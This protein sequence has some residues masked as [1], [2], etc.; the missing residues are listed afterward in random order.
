MSSKLITARKGYKKPIRDRST[1]INK[2]IL[3]GISTTNGNLF[4]YGGP[5]DDVYYNSAKTTGQDKNNNGT[6]TGTSTGYNLGDLFSSIGSIFNGSSGGS[7]EGTGT[8][9]VK[10]GMSKGTKQAIAGGITTA[11]SL[12]GNAFKSGNNHDNT[13]KTLGMAGT[14]LQTAGTLSGNVWLTAAGTA[15]KLADDL[16]FTYG[17][18][19]EGAMRDNTARLRNTN[20]TGRNNS[21]LINQYK[22]A[23]LYT[24]GPGKISNG[25]GTDEGDE[26]ARSLS[27]EQDQAYSQAF[28]NFRNAVNNA[29]KNQYANQ[30]YYYSNDYP[31]FTAFGGQLDIKD[32]DTNIH[33]NMINNKFPF[34]GYYET[35]DPSTAIGYSLYTDK[36]INNNNK[37]QSSM[38]NLFAG[39]PGSMFSLGGTTNT[40]GASFGTGLTH[41][42]TGGSHE[43]NPNDGVQ[44]GVDS[45]NVPNL[46]EEGEVIYDDYVFSNRLTIPNYKKEYDKKK[47]APYEA[48]VLWNYSD[49]SFAD[50]AKKIEKNTG[51]S[52]RPED[53]VSQR[54]ME[55]DLQVLAQVQEKER[56]KE[57]LKEIQEAIDNMTP[58]EFAA[59]QQQMQ[60]M[61]QQSQQEEIAQQEQL[62]Q[63]EAMQQQQPSEEELAAMQQQQMAAQEMQ[64][65][66]APQQMMAAN[67]GPINQN[68][69]SEGGILNTP[70]NMYP[71]GGDFAKFTQEL[72]DRG[73]TVDDYLRYLLSQGKIDQD[74]MDFY[75]VSDNNRDLL[76]DSFD[77]DLAEQY[78]KNLK[79]REKQVARLYRK[80]NKDPKKLTGA[81]LQKYKEDVLKAS[82]NPSLLENDADKELFVNQVGKGDT[83]SFNIAATDAITKETRQAYFGNPM[84]AQENGKFAI[85]Y[86]RPE[87]AADDWQPRSADLIKNPITI[88]EGRFVDS[89]GNEIANPF[90][91]DYGFTSPS[92][93]WKKYGYVNP[94]DS[95]WTNVEYNPPTDASGNTDYKYTP[96]NDWFKQSGMEADKYEAQDAYLNNYLDFLDDI[97]NDESPNHQAALRRLY[98]MGEAT[99][100]NAPGELK[101]KNRYFDTDKEGFDANNLSLDNLR[102]VDGNNTIGGRYVSG[103]SPIQGVSDPQYA[104]RQYYADKDGRLAGPKYY[105]DLDEE[106]KKNYTPL[107]HK[108]L[109]RQ[110]LLNNLKARR[111]DNYDTDPQ[112]LL[113]SSMFDN[114]PAQSYLMAPKAS[115]RYALVDNNGKYILDANNQVQY[116]NPDVADNPLYS[117]YNEGNPIVTDTLGDTTVNTIGVLG[118]NYS[119]HIAVVDGKYYNLSPEQ[120][121]QFAKYKVTDPNKISSYTGFDTPIT[122]YS[123]NPTYY[124]IPEEG[125]AEAGLGVLS[126]NTDREKDPFPKAPTWPFLAGL[127]LQLGSLGYNILSPKDYSNA[128]AM[129][130]AAQ[131]AGKYTPVS[132][133]P[134]G[135]YLK[136]TPDD[137]W[138]Y[139]SPVMAQSNAT[140]RMINNRISPSNDAASIANTY[141]TMVALGQGTRQQLDNNFNKY[142]KVGEY[143]KDTDKFDSEGFLKADMANQDAA[144]RARGFNLEGLKSG[145]AMKQA[146]DDA[147]ANAINAGIS[148]IGNL[149]Y[150]YAG[151]KYNQDV[152]GWGIRHNAYA[153]QDV[154]AKKGGKLKRRKKGLSF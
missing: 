26:L 32:K 58:E 120:A 10:K 25:W 142:A 33:T 95:S 100:S 36:Y 79:T 128:D 27:K 147:K 84:S 87:G 152:L 132:F 70:D 119:P 20:F 137:P 114:V 110:D 44:V 146:I 29:T 89:K 153:P 149:L 133:N 69:F 11:G 121:A 116:L 24:V 62:A 68:T 102:I 151:N 46:V 141:N 63:Q 43:E 74:T 98:E 7:N 18:E 12:I 118:G 80:N 71:Y 21:D 4:L 109:T 83:K 75:T 57:K 59:L 91:G 54:G 85:D 97:Y 148:G 117:I 103:V 108:G 53:N 136:Y 47:E 150:S 111:N 23:R 34:G 140:N 65:A 38:T 105:S 14:A 138:F 3:D 17:V 48:Q 30:M 55:S 60:M 106:Q 139:T 107:E 101:G 39:T 1:Y 41:V 129:I 124:E 40:N 143:N 37:N 73:L 42:D 5:S 134:I 8:D 126:K 88:S 99:K 113:F 130:K 131:N 9:T 93:D 31:N 112:D 22:N 76:S 16:F 61:Q 51:A 64:Q 67:G 81:G 115:N 13:G 2:G 35:V 52:E 78:L 56:E 77:K 125:M 45:Q 15:A 66:A 72:A 127:G 123:V 50:A 96:W 145:Y 19:N 144:T 135:N 6:T 82:R 154:R 122:G 94:K 86:G 92:R 104:N 49:L 90:E 28:G